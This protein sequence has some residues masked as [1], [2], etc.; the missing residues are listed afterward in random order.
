MSA[1]ILALWLAG[2]LLLTRCL[3]GDGCTRKLAPFKFW[4][5]PP[6]T[7]GDVILRQ[8]KEAKERNIQILFHSFIGQIHLHLNRYWHSTADLDTRRRKK[9]PIISDMTLCLSFRFYTLSLVISLF[10]FWEIIKTTMKCSIKKFVWH[11][12]VNSG[13]TL[14]NKQSKNT[15]PN[16]PATADDGLFHAICEYTVTASFKYWFEFW[17][18][19]PTPPGGGGGTS[20]VLR[21]RYVL[22]ERSAF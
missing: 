10:Y 12:L 11:I 16:I 4:I 6:M 22:R 15:N 14:S 2:R 8:C 13:L 5:L 7:C 3:G 9:L 19:S 1:V 18:R 17:R 20:Y 21:I